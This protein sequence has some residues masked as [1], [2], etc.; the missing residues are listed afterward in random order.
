M[1]NIALLLL[2]ALLLPAVVGC[3]SGAPADTSTQPDTQAASSDTLQDTTSGDSLSDRALVSDDLPQKDFGGREYIILTDDYQVKD[4]VSDG[5]TGEVINDAVYK[6]NMKVEERFGVKIK[7]YNPGD[8]NATASAAKKDVLAG[9]GSFHLYAAH[10]VAAGGNVL[11]NIFADWNEVPYVDFSKP[12]WSSSNDAQLTYDGKVILAMGD[13]AMSTLY[14]TYC[15]YFNKKLAGQYS[16]PDIYALVDSGEWTIDKVSELT[17][18]IYTDL[19]N[20][21]TRDKG[22]FYGFVQDVHSLDMYLWAFDNPVMVKD[23]E[24]KPTL[25]I[26][27]PKMSTILTKLYDICYV[28]NGTY[29][30][31]SDTGKTGDKNVGRDLFEE[32]RSVIAPGHLQMAMENFRLMEDD[33]GIVPM[34]KFDKTQERYYSMTGGSMAGLAVPKTLT[35]EDYEFFGIITEALSAESWKTAHPA[36]Y[37]VALKVKGARDEQSVRMLDLVMSSRVYDFGYVYDNWQGM[38]F[39]VQFM[40]LKGDTNF[41]SYYEKK[42]AAAIKYYDKV[43]AAFDALNS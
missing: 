2:L 26:N 10:L 42:E 35:Q 22:D 9:E 33:Y 24:G 8:Y 28:N 19:N 6:R 3:S 14:K 23:G 17:K 32:N 34:P 37:D 39:T 7:V 25:S 31:S 1:R 18:D 40:L 38:A 16:L 29:F 36:Y 20:D 41:Q 30:S 12:W 13:L 27:T 11:S 5:E 15:Y 43:I 21:G 4:M